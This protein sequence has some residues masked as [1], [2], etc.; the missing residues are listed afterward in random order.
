MQCE[1]NRSNTKSY[2]GRGNEVQCYSLYV[3]GVVGKI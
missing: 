1:S 3:M 2:E